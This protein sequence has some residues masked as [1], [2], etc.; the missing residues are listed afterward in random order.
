MENNIIGMNLIASQFYSCNKNK[1][2]HILLLMNLRILNFD[3]LLL[4]QLVQLTDLAI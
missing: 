4:A 2:E 1:I 3:Q